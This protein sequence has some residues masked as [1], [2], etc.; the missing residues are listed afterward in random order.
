MLEGSLDA[1]PNPLRATRWFV[2]GWMGW[3]WPLNEPA[4]R[5]EAG[6]GTRVFGSDELYARG[7]F[8]NVLSGL[9]D[10]Q[11]GIQLGYRLRIGD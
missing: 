8:G 6:L 4:Y 5:L 9:D 7:Y 1:V 3:Q 10:V 2:D 11:A